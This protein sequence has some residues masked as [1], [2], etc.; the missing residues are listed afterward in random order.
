MQRSR[1][2]GFMRIFFGLAFLFCAA[3]IHAQT[4]QDTTALYEYL[5]QYIDQSGLDKS[6]LKK[7]SAF[8]A[9]I[10]DK[11]LD[12][13]RIIPTSG[14]PVDTVQTDSL[15]RDLNR[16]ILIGKAYGD[17]IVL[18]W[19]PSNKDFW[20]LANEKGYV[21]KRYTMLPDS[22]RLD[23]NSEKVIAGDPLPLIHPWTFD[24]I[25]STLQEKDSMALIVA[26][27]IYGS[28]FDKSGPS[29]SIVLRNMEE[30]NF[31]GFT[32]LCADRSP[33]AAEVAGLRFADYQ[34]KP[35]QSYVYMIQSPADTNITATSYFQVI[36]MPFPAER[37]RNIFTVSHDGKV[38]IYWSKQ[39]NSGMSAFILERSEDGGKTFRRI[40]NNPLIYDGEVSVGKPVFVE[41]GKWG[42]KDYQLID[43]NGYFLFQD[44]VP[45]ND[46]EF[47]YRLSGIN[48][49]GE[50]SEY[51]TFTGAGRDLTPPA[52]PNIIE[53]EQ[54]PDGH[55]R[56]RW[57]NGHDPDLKGFRVLQST[58]E[59]GDY[60]P[61]SPQILPPE[62]DLFVT[63]DTLDM[64][65]THYF[66]IE[67]L[68][69]HGNSSFSYPT[70]IHVI[71]SIAPAPPKRIRH[72][73]DSTGVV[74]L[75]W[76]M[77]KEE[78]LAGYR[79]YFSNRRDYEMTQLTKD[80]IPVNFFRDTIEVKTLTET[81][82]YAV[83]AVDRNFNRSAFSDIIEV[84]KPDVIPPVAPVF[85]FPEVSDSFIS[86]R[87][88]PS[89]SY[90]VVEHILYRRN[91]GDTAW[92]A[93]A[94]LGNLDSAYVDKSARAE[95]L[96]EYSL[97]A[98]DDAGLFSPYAF[99]VNGRRY[100]NDKLLSVTDFQV[101]FDSTGRAMQLKWKFQAPDIDLLKGV[102]YQFYL[103]R[104]VGAGLPERYK[105][106]DGNL[107]AFTDKAIREKGQYNYS[108]CVMFK[109]GKTSELSSI[110]S[111]S[112]VKKQ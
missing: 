11:G 18:R 15:Q 52:N 111:A 74:T 97:R 59:G 3:C 104:S 105:L 92:V 13:E 62:A 46:Q 42:D 56:L 47:I 81:I 55:A 36:N 49:F 28:S 24:K 99:P 39:D 96:Y 50:T 8:Q 83:Q 37:P 14:I 10:K 45:K 109:N 31:Y 98:K 95:Q 32:L 60:K 21:L 17:S 5:Q 6:F 107:R 89:S 26:Q 94:Q 70:Y 110:V 84:K 78:D 30:N 108:I 80:A 79:V 27:T 35:G 61:V 103:Y 33:L 112:N 73:I 34:V 88:A 4:K 63:P 16:I 68:D 67:A 85:Q 101:A 57:I 76:D 90:D 54:L 19:A 58:T 2:T 53:R 22:F 44:S 69:T 77:G 9:L 71:D 25:A 66:K 29:D 64:R 38:N 86:L 51:A 40:H 1:Y 72:F 82:Y 20:R 100:F 91:F 7:D 106:L 87:W 48:P 23:K 12:M 41:K 65:V 43:L 102:E 93:I 75:G